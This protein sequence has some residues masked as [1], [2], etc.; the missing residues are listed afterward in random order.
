MTMQQMQYYELNTKKQYAIFNQRDR[1][2]VYF[3]PVTND[4]R[5]FYLQRTGFEPAR[6]FT[7]LPC[8]V[9]S[10]LS[11]CSPE[12]LQSWITLA[13]LLVTQLPLT[14]SDGNRCRSA[15]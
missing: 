12:L 14:A 1:S 2:I 13:T 10:R 4:V 11:R 9:A 5:G 6:S 15:T 8:K 7:F 3:R